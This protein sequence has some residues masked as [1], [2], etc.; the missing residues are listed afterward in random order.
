MCPGW[1]ETGELYTFCGGRCPGSDQSG[2]SDM[3]GPN[4][5]H[6]VSVG[7]EGIFKVVASL[8]PEKSGQFFN[9]KGERV[10]W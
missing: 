7:V 10:P 3:G 1:L 2:T 9:F 5:M 6:P 8:T 4:A